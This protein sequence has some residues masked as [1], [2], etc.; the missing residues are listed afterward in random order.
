M[1]D[2][3]YEREV[4]WI[5][6][7]N[8]KSI[9]TKHVILLLLIFA[10]IYVVG[11][12]L[13]GIYFGYYESTVKLS[14]W[15]IFNYIIPFALL[16]ISSEVIRNVLIVQKNKSSKLMTLVITVLIDVII[17]TG[18]YDI[19][20]LDGFL[21]IIGFI[22]FASV[23]CNLLYNY[24]SIRFGM[25]SIIIYRLITTLYLYIFS[26]VPS[27]PDYFDSFIGMLLP[28]VIFVFI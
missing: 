16:I 25:L 24:I 8:I 6:K 5:K 17:Y 21:A 1:E 23:S 10:I 22:V 15:S 14:I 3:G 7:R 28:L 18:I 27:V 20:T 12:Y 4:F 2:D 11:Y 9:H 26:I 13:L 19:T